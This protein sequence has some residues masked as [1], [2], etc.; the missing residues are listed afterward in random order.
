MIDDFDQVLSPAQVIDQVARI[1]AVVIHLVDGD[2]PLSEVR[3]VLR[4]EARKAR[5][6]I[7]VMH[8][9]RS[10]VVSDPD[11]VVDATRLR[12]AVDHIQIPG[13]PAPRHLHVVPDPGN[14]PA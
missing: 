7:S 1:G 11:H 5:L 12:D 9:D 14:P 8:Y 6:Q 2:P 10:L 4:T 3:R 13:P